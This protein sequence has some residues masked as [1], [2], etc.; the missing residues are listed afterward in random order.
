MQRARQNTSLWTSNHGTIPSD[1]VILI[2]LNIPLV[3]L[4]WRNIFGDP[5]E[6]LECLRLWFT[7]DWISVLNGEWSEDF[8]AEMKLAALVRM[9]GNAVALERLIFVKIGLA[10]ERPTNFYRSRCMSIMRT[11]SR[12]PNFSP[13][14]RMMPTVPK[15]I[16]SWKR[17]L[18]GFCS[19]TRAT[20][21]HT[22]PA[23]PS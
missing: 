15:P 18:P 21:T 6:F 23:F 14:R 20:R 13:T 9:C 2:A 11:S 19:T 3:V 17:T 16:R 22:P 1:W 5:D 12:R 10:H 8:W 7:P 4:V